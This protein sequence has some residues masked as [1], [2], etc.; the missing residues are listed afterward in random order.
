MH[1]ASE[2]NYIAYLEL[3]GII[4]LFFESDRYMTSAQ[5]AECS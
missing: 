5:Q 4:N 2:L 1:T 3:T